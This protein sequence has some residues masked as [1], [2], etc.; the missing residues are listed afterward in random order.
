MSFRSAL[1][2]YTHAKILFD[3]PMKKHTAFG[4]GGKVAYYTEIDS[5]Y[6]LN[7]IT[8]LAKRHRIRCRVLGAGTN[9]LVSDSGFDGVIICTKRLSDVFFK[10]DQVRAMAGAS[11]DKLIKFCLEHNLSGLEALSGIPATVGGAVVMNAG[12]F[13]HTVSEN[14]VTVETLNNGKIKVYDKDECKF[15]YRGSRF[16]G[17]RETVI[18]ATFKFETKPKD[19]ISSA[20]KSYKELRRNI[21]PTGKSCGSVF[22]NPLPQTAGN[23]IDRAGLKGYT[24]GGASISKKHGNF[25]TVTSSATATDVYNLIQYAKIKVKEV[26]G[27]ELSEEVEYV[28]KF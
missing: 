12:A 16:L 15:V 13:G 3:E 20:V 10:V 2:T 17:A 8:A 19:V 25:I 27:I 14:I 24:V 4:I 9:V 21:Q 22:K 5:L 7:T 6:T 23:L 11:L 26:F 28:G 18:S 1:E